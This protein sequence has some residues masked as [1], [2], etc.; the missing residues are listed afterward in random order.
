MNTEFRKDLI[1]WNKG[2]EFRA[3]QKERWEND[4]GMQVNYFKAIFKRDHGIIPIDNFSFDKY[5]EAKILQSK[6]RRSLNV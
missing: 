4:H 6:I 3:G 1:P 5:I 2:K